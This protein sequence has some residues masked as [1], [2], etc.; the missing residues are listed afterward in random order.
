MC[1]CVCC[2]ECACVRRMTDCTPATMA[3]TPPPPLCSPHLAAGPPTI[4]SPQ[5]PSPQ[6]HWA[7]TNIHGAAT[8]HAITLDTPFSLSISISLS[9]QRAS[10]SASLYIFQPSVHPLLLSPFF[11]AHCPSFPSL[12]FFCSVLVISSLPFHVGRA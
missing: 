1:V 12:L 7:S 8:V 10:S 3:L 9:L 6:Q 2:R 4:N 11:F 5:H